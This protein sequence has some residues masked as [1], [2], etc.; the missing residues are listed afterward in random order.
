MPKIF[1]T[2]SAILAITLA[3][4]SFLIL[5][6]WNAIPGDKLYGL[7]RNL[8]KVPQLALGNSKYG[9]NYDVFLVERRF[10]EADKLANSNETLG[11]SNL[12]DSIAQAKQ[13]VLISQSDQARTQLISNLTQYNQKLEE[14]K[15][16]LVALTPAP[17]PTPTPTRQ[18][19]SAIIQ[20]KNS[21][22]PVAPQ[23]T[24]TV[25]AINNTQNEIKKT[26][27][28]LNK[29][30]P[31]STQIQQ[32]AEQ[33]ATQPKKDSEDKKT[34]ESKQESKDKNDENQ[35]KDKKDEKN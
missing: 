34:T 11:L 32:P 2:I 10:D 22:L 1:T 15:T 9:A 26:I 19:T 29:A 24:P 27:E 35:K 8:E 13:K 3:L 7:K 4:P 16:Q 30:A 14:R 23:P 31:A 18:P 17:A 6:S 21:T 12:N 28:D 33:P 25:T 20:P 5:I